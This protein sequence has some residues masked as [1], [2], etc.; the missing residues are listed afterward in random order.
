MI[1]VKNLSD[2]AGQSWNVYHHKVDASN[3]QNYTIFLNSNSARS[4]EQVWNDY[5]PTSTVFQIGSARK[6]NYNNDDYIAYCFA[7]KTGYSRFGSYVGNGNADGAFIYTGF[8]PAWIMVKR[9][10]STGSWFMFDNKRDGYNSKN[11]RLM[12]D[13]DDTEADPGG[14]DI[15]SNGFKL[16]FTS[17]NANGSGA[18]YI[19]M[20]FG[21]SLVGSNNVPCT[22]R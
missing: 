20:A 4:D 5:S 15:L 1:I 21:Q 13:T 16:R 14:F 12:A 17:G 10:D 22:A 8:K 3:P 2:S 7:E 6:T 18:S 11:D 9:T 19:Y